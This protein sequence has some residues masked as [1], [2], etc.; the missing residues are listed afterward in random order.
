M[1]SQNAR[2]ISFTEHHASLLDELVGTGRYQTTSEVVRD[3]LRALEAEISARCR[4]T[5][6]DTSALPR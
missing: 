6:G 4:G 1:P 3:G 5:R 2:T